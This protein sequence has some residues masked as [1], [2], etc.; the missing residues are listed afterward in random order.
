MIVQKL[1]SVYACIILLIFQYITLHCKN[2]P[3]ITL[4]R[5]H[6]QLEWYLFIG[7]IF[8]GQDLQVI[9]NP[10]QNASDQNPCGQNSNHLLQMWTKS[11]PILDVDCGM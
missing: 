7:T 11:H 5:V 3:K 10:G 4:L 9:T 6:S 8:P 1:L 2:V